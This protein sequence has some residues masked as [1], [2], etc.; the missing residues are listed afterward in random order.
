MKLLQV[1]TYIVK[2]WKSAVWSGP[3]CARKTTRVCF[4]VTSTF[5]HRVR[6][7]TYTDGPGNRV[8]AVRRHLRC[9]ARGNETRGAAAAVDVACT[10]FGNNWNN[11]R[12]IGNGPFLTRGHRRIREMSQA[13]NTMCTHTRAPPPV[14]KKKKIYFERL[15]SRRAHWQRWESIWSVLL[16]AAHFLIL[17]SAYV[18]VQ[19]LLFFGAF[20]RVGKLISLTINFVL[21][22]VITPSMCLHRTQNNIF[23]Y[24]TF[25]FQ[26]KDNAY[27]W[28]LQ[29]PSKM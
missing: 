11:Y 23:I 16:A 9:L 14:K 4:F 1:Y 2:T 18:V 19:T 25:T 10:R 13:H 24:L 6:F 5:T 3:A 27:S 15:R 22:I 29:V 28:W 7:I 21:V 26:S 8:S 20:A 17:Y 12:S